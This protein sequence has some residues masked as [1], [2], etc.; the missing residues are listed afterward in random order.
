M[1]AYRFAV[2]WGAVLLGAACADSGRALSTGLE[3]VQ[4]RGAPA[5]APV[6]PGP[7]GAV[8]PQAPELLYAEPSPLP[9]KHALRVGLQPSGALRLHDVQAAEVDVEVSGGAVGAHEVSALF[10]SPQ[11]LAWERQAQRVT[12]APG[13]TATV[14]FT[15][16][17]ANTLIEDH[18]LSGRWTVTTLDDGVEQA[19]TTFEVTP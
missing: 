13:A 2:A 7:P 6:S 12:L 18:A 19:A 8:L 1:V 17:V 14:R 3:A 9:V 10:V 11:G 15:L 16:P 5:P 4:V